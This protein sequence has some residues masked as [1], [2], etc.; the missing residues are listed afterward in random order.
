MRANSSVGGFVV[1]TVSCVL[2]GFAACA[3]NGAG[4]DP[5]DISADS[6]TGG[7]GFG[8][9]GGLDL[10]ALGDRK[11]IK[12]TV[13]PADK[14]LVVK[15][16]DVST[17]SI[18]YTATALL[19]DGAT[20]PVPSCIWTIDRIDL[21]SFK[22]STFTASGGAGGIG[23]V[24]C[25]ALGLSASTSVTVEL[26]DELDS[27]SGLDDAGKAALLAATTK[28]PTIDKLLYPYDGTIFPRGLTPPELMW[29]GGGTS[30]VY[31]VTL[32]VPH[33]TYTAFVKAPSP[34]RVTVSKEIWNKLLD[35]STPKDPMKM[36]V[37]R[38]AGGAGGTV[39]FT[40]SQKWTIAAANLKGSIYYWRI[41]G[42]KIVRI[43]PGASAPEDFLKLSTGKTCV[44]CHSV[45]HDGSTLVGSY[46]GTP[47]FPAGVFDPKT[48]TEGALVASETMF[49]AAYPDGSAYLATKTASAATLHTTT[50]ASLEPSGAAA[51]GNALSHP[52]FSPDGKWLAFSV[53]KDGN[54]ADFNQSDLMI[55]PFDA[56]TKKFGAAK[57]L[58]A[59][60][61]R[62]L[63]YPSFTPDGQWIIYMDATQSTR[64]GKG[65]LHFIKPDGTSDISL[66][67]L[68]SSGIAKEDLAL[69]FEPT[70]GPVLSGGYFWVV[71]VSTR[72]YGNRLNKTYDAFRDV[73]GKPGWDKTP[74]RN[75]QLWVAAIDAS[76]TAGKDPSHAAFWLP[77]QD[78]G[79]QNMRGYWA[80]DPCKK[81]GEGC[82]AGFECCEGTCKADAPGSG[83][84]CVKPEP[85]KCKDTGDKC[86][87]NEDC[88]DR[89]LGIEC[90]GGVCANKRPA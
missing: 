5:I 77:G 37:R 27:G 61:G 86:E 44:A 32:E 90:V 47:V 52:A 85:G 78:L 12:L 84:K 29:N 70:F 20:L 82:E 80:L 7:D 34:S 69:N 35:T 3:P 76:P 59:S 72:Q 68:N 19:S 63:T 88:C 74:C 41:N 36:T 24:S 26:K 65:D 8:L 38:S 87:K 89:P 25:A 56:A 23:K 11:V 75:K 79:D 57:L 4:Q 60:G 83:K 64:P 30:D 18:P 54:W 81:L 22:A 16:G 51:F 45:S 48:G 62:T 53:R 17:A 15:N 28:D 9:D 1:V 33:M 2:A 39:F 10:D 21:G 73:C 42:G 66:A 46:E 58:R 14:T 13:E 67:T 49:S 50:G 31:A 55:A 40:T 6:S 43:K 71:F